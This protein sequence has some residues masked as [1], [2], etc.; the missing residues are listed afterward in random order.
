MS[1]KL[2]FLGGVGEIGMNCLV[3][4]QHAGDRQERLLIDC[5]V[6]FPG[7]EGGVDLYHPRF[8]YLLEAPERLVG[9]VLTHGHEDHYGAVAYLLDALPRDLRVWGPPYV[10]ELLTARLSETEGLLERASLVPIEPGMR[11]TAGSFHIE[12]LRV[13]HSVVDA[14]ALSIDTAAGRVVHTGDFKLDGDPPDGEPTDETRF[15]ALGDEGVALLLSDSTNA[16]VD[17]CSGGERMV[18]SAIERAIAAASG[19]VVVG[20]FASNAHRLNAVGRA[21]R[22]HGRRLCLLGRSM[23]TH[24]DVARKLKRLDWPSDLLVSPELAQRLPRHQLVYLVTGTQGEPRAVLRRL[25]GGYHPDLRLEPGDS[26]VLSSRAIP[27]NERLVQVLMDELL[28]IGVRLSSWHR[29]RE[30]HVS[31]HAHRDEQRR[32]IALTKPAAFIPLHGTRMGLEE[33]AAL[34]RAAGV[35]DVMV[36]TN[37]GTAL[38]GGDGLRAGEPVPFSKMGRSGT[39]DVDDDSL[40]E[41][42]R[43]GRAGV[44]F[45]ALGGTGGPVVR[46]RGLPPDAVEEANRLVRDALASAPDRADAATMI[47]GVERAVRQ[48]LGEL[49]GN[50]PLV[51]VVVLG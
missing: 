46:T 26:V 51:D 1:L 3:L 44:V 34:A 23:H 22:A 18:G 9:V 48:R 29:D 10:L 37:G 7:A 50:R 15:A 30:L 47:E 42:R 13:T 25:A 24:S 49:L 38:L 4:E 12:A 27:G 40:R 2:A 28:A 21:A 11:F 8:D 31:G 6:M 17:G 32:M 16:T 41:R 20:V 43:M 45:V 14:L 39:M 5:G 36:V 19:R 33:H 35:R